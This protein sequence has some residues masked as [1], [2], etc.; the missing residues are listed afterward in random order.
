MRKDWATRASLLR[1][2]CHQPPT[3]AALRR[4]AGRTLVLPAA[5]GAQGSQGSQGRRETKGGGGRWRHRLRGSRP[6]C[7]GLPLPGA[8]ALPQVLRSH[9]SPAGPAL[10]RGD[11]APTS[12]GQRRPQTHAH[13][14]R[15]RFS[16][17]VDDAAV[18]QADLEELHP[19]HAAALAGRPRTDAPSRRR[20]TSPAFPAPPPTLPAGPAH[21]P[22]PAPRPSPASPQL[23]GPLLPAFP[24]APGLQPSSALHRALPG[25]VLRLFPLLSTTNSLPLPSPPATRARPRGG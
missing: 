17:A 15:Q 13:G 25:S 6:Q 20:A 16:R 1:P 2:H 12:E 22:V 19:P 8:P 23:Q 10:P 24:P 21:S 3:P 4:P 7:H 18:A 11:P 5:G 14:P 9:L